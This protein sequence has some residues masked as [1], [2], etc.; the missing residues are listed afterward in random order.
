V[1]KA[2]RFKALPWAMLSQPNN[3]PFNAVRR[4]MK[5]LAQNP[6]TKEKSDA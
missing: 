3:R 1:G 6:P 5:Q 2:K 4:G